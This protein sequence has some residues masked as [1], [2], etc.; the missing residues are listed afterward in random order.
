MLNTNPSKRRR[1]NNDELRLFAEMRELRSQV[2]ARNADLGEAEAE[3]LADE[4]TD[5]A[6]ASLVARGAIR[7]ER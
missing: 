3:I 5:E 4:A 6:V 7:F 1:N 2:S